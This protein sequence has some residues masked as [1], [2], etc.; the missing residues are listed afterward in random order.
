MFISKKTI[1]DLLRVIFERLLRDGARISA[2]KGAN[3]E[4]TGV[5][6][7]LQNPR[8]RLSRTETKGT[9][10]SCLGEVLWYLAGSRELDFIEYY[11]HE[12]RKFSDDGKTVYGAYGPRLLNKDGSIPQL[13]NIVRLLKQ[14]R[15]TRQAVIQLYDA[16]DIVE[17]HND[18]PCTC[19]IQFLIRR[20]KL[21]MFTFMRS[22]DAFKGLPHD[23]FSFTFLQEI[24]ARTV[25]AEL[26]RY[27]HAA[28]SLHLYDEDKPKVQRFLKEGWQATNM[29]MPDMPIGDPWP[30]IR[31]VLDAEAQIRQKK[32]IQADDLR[33]PH[34][35][36]DLVRILQ[37]FASDAR[38]IPVLKTLMHSN[39]YDTYIEKRAQA[40]GK[41]SK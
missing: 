5:S 19:A 23:I 18:I 17:K 41:S 28:T 31:M 22:N 32:K 25:G 7:E 15:T 30:H 3:T 36:T 11:L 24:V 9:V 12:Y 40:S 33:L 27:W 20:N 8:A 4:L 29:P 1:D 35:W 16:E 21:H 38:T 2:S 6:L 10:F 39:I 14:R 34:Y 37:I 13:S 26:G